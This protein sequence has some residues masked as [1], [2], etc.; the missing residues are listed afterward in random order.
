MAK[1]AGSRR[2]PKPERIWRDA[3]FWRVFVHRNAPA[4]TSAARRASWYSLARPD[5]VDHERGDF[6]TP[7]RPPLP[8]RR[9][10]HEAA[11]RPE[12]VHAARQPEGRVRPH[13]RLEALA[14]VPHLLHDSVGPVLLE[15]EQPARVLAGAQHA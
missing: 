3:R 11:L 10:V 6:L 2:K 5:R 4:S 8:Q 7:R 1:P 13:V 15:P 14:V 9:R 12:L